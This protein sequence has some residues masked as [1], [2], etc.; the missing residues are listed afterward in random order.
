M[1]SVFIS[2]SLQEFNPYVDG[3]NEEYY[4]NL[5]AD[6]LIPYL[7]ASGITVG[8]NSPEQSLRQAIDQSNQGDYD[9]HLAIHSNASPPNMAGQLQGADV[10]YYPYSVKGKSAATIIADNYKAIYPN[11]NLVKLVPSTTLAELRLTKAPAVLIEVAYH[12]NP[13]DAQWI[14]DNIGNIARNLA[15]SVTEFLDVPFV[16]P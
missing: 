9:L 5:I 10:Y 3:G 11:P 13:Q 6:E 12:D 14:R 8:R 7:I 15:L 4:M 2:P 1:P 16:Q